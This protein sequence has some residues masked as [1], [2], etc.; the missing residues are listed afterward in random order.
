MSQYDTFVHAMIWTCRTCGFAYF[1]GQPKME[2]P[3]CESYKTNFVDIPQ[4]IE[5]KIR[6]ELPDNPPNHRDNRA[7]RVELMA[8]ETVKPR[9]AGRIL[10]AASGNHMDPSTPD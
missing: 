5:A 10:P 3:V 6:E 1:G 9:A 7:R 8:E 4:H 2:C